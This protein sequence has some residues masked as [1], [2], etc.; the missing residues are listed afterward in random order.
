MRFN[1]RIAGLTAAVTMT[2]GAI[3]WVAAPVASASAAPGTGHAYGAYAAVSLLPGVLGRGGL[4]V[5]TGTLARSSTDGPSSA[6]VADVPLRGVV[7]A[8]AITSSSESSAGTVRVTAAILDARLPV[9][10]GAVGGT[11]SVRVLRAKCVGT[12]AGVTGSSEIAGLDLGRLG[13]IPIS[14]KP[15]QTV[16]V[17]QLARIVV[18]EQHRAADGSLTVTALHVSLLGGRVTNA[19]GHGDIR[20]ASA[21]CGRGSGGT[22]TTPPT[23]PEQPGGGDGGGQT[24]G[25]NGGTGGNGSQVKVIPSGAPQTGDGTMAALR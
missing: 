15:N 18:N 9:L 10:A 8:K 25:D 16:D 5:D 1:A 21:T 4:T 14:G 22:T 11:P 17:P 7:H 24:G 6:S 3:A 23:T 20:L 19:L 12:G 2:G 13:T